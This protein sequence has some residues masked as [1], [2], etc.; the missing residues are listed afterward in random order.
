MNANRWVGGWVS[1]GGKDSFLVE[2]ILYHTK[3]PV[4][5][6]SQTQHSTRDTE[7]INFPSPYPY[8]YLAFYKHASIAFLISL[9]FAP[10]TP[11]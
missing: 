10:V 5:H 1:E 9:G 4:M 11:S 6:N 8:L 2:H 3:F 7:H